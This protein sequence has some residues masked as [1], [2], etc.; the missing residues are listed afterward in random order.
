MAIRGG[1]A[2]DHGD[3]QEQA[4]TG[5]RMILE[6]RSDNEAVADVVD[7]E[8]AVTEHRPDV[9]PLD[10]PTPRL[11]GL[12]VTR[13][14]AGQNAPRSVTVTVIV[15]TFDLDEYEDVR[16]AL[17]G[18]ASGSLLEDAGTAPLVEAVRASAVGNSLVPPATSMRL[19]GAWPPDPTRPPPH[20]AATAST[21]T[22]VRVGRGTVAAGLE[23]RSA[24]N[25]AHL[26]RLS[27]SARGGYGLAGTTERTEAP[28]GSLAAGPTSEGGWP[29][30]APAAVKH[31]GPGQARA[32]GSATRTR[33]AR[34]VPRRVSGLPRTCSTRELLRFACTAPDTAGSAGMIRKTR[35]ATCRRSPV[36]P[37]G[38][39]GGRHALA[40]R[41]GAQCRQMPLVDGPALGCQ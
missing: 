14:L 7:G 6:S 16:A 8:A 29:V 12:E 20:V 18:G 30:T 39:L 17:H 36:W 41:D 23:V 37:A 1:S 26:A 3:A 5:V 9:L 2:D 38:R 28:G 34:G 19:L 13:R 21:A 25:G 4:G 33:P 11:D 24:D 10:V 15:T 27:E 32:G 22:A 40:Q 35:P 31:R